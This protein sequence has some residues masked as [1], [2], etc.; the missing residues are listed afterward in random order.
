MISYS[1]FRGTNGYP[2][3][4]NRKKEKNE[5][6]K[7]FTSRQPMRKSRRNKMQFFRNDEFSYF[8]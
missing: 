5:K 2:A 8:I 4:E 3:D 7:N 6:K 1:R